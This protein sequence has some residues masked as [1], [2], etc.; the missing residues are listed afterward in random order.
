MGRFKTLAL[1]FEVPRTDVRLHWHE[2]FEQD[3]GNGWLRGVL[4]DL[5]AER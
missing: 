4:V 3:P 2:R 1:P 5:Y